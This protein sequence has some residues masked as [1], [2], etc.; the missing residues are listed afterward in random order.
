MKKKAAGR[1]KNQFGKNEV[2]KRAAVMNLTWLVVW[3]LS[4]AGMAVFYEL[5]CQAVIGAVYQSNPSAGILVTNH[6]FMAK[7]NYENLI[8]AASAVY[9]SGYTEQGILW[10]T[11]YA[12]GKGFLL[13]GIVILAVMGLLSWRYV[14]KIG[15]SDVYALLESDKVQIKKC[16][17]EL[18]AALR[19]T[20]RKE[21]QV[22]KFTEN[23][24]HQIK[25]PLA[26]LSLLLDV[27]R[28]EIPQEQT[29]QNDI[30]QCFLHVERIKEFIRQLLTISRIE[31]GKVR[32]I[33][34]PVSISGLF[35]NVRQAVQT[36][37]KLTFDCEDK[38]AQIYADGQWITEALINLV[39][40][41]C[42][43]ARAAQQMQEQPEVKIVAVVHVDKCVIKVVDNGN[44][45]AD[46]D[47]THLFDRFETQGDY[48]SFQTGIG[49]NLSRLVVE[50]HSGTIQAY[51]RQ[52]GQ[53]AVF[54]VVLPQFALK[55]GKI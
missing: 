25:T 38:D 41:A 45:F 7:I 4:F 42:R 16:R 49:L 14:K 5:K 24:A 52:D 39:E 22:Q 2:R 46:G 36:D 26:G 20:K 47:T 35:E 54:R 15:G 34:E 32:F 44:G 50:A 40:N 43:A 12:G 53:G 51:N 27:I 37:C 3:L 31:A 11:W 13:A 30:A 21:E 9:E 6:M 23:I 17:E 28:E 29:I 10:L 18:E 55:Q 19:Y 8:S 1:T 33:K 48:A